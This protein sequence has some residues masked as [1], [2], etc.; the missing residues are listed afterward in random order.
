MGVYLVNTQQMQAAE[1]AA[2]AAG[3][4]Y[5]TMM[6][7]AGAAVAEAIDAEFG[8]AGSRVL[9]LVGPG[10]NGGDGLVAARYL[11]ERGAVVTTYIWRRNVEND[12]NWRLACE[13]GVGAEWMSEDAGLERLARLVDE[14]AIVVDA[15]LGTGVARPIGGDLAAL[16]TRAREVIDARRTINM[17]QLVD[18]ADP[19]ELDEF[20]PFLVALDVPSGLNSDTGAL[21]LYT[22]PADLTVTLAAPKLGQVLFPG[23]AY[24]G[25][26]LVADIG[27]GAELFQDVSTGL[28]DPAMVAAWL[29]QR[30]VGAHKGTFGK[31]L[32][33]A[34]SVNYVGAPAL[35]ASAA[36]RV[37][38]GLVTLALPQTIFPI[39]ASHH[40]EPTYLLLADEMGVLA[41]AAVKVLAEKVAGYTA[42]LLG[43]GFGQEASTAAFLETLLAGIETRRTKAERI[44]FRGVASSPEPETKTQSLPPLVLDADGLNLLAKGED[45]WLHLPQE[46]ILTPHPGEMARLMRTTVRDVEA[47][48]IGIAADMARK[49]GQ[50]VVLKGAHTVIAAPAGQIVVLPFAN[51]ALATAGSGDV[52]A[53]SI[54]GLRAQGLAAFEAA[55]AGAYLHGLAGESAR[56]EVGEVGVV[57]GDLAER[58]PVA[59]RLVLGG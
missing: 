7:N 30:P 47:N 54:V 34:G 4:S 8:A 19:P 35:A 46:S 25:R 28:A 45:W 9:V 18:P 55:V 26:L 15:L 38:A 42:L 41:P 16:L 14:A 48:R 6:E 2:D 10:N 40:P 31:A 50:V 1:R 52:L 12:K 53:G 49:W 32:I 58:L 29:P 21:D 36:T 27:I 59:I 11:A 23:A 44:G 51:P 24:V 20:G 22:L 56:D 17:P 33:V 3:L 5:E 37:G 13:R 39:V 43:P 57:A